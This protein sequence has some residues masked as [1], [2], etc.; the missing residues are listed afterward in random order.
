MKILQK[1][2]ID[3]VNGG[4]SLRRIAADSGVE[5]TSI[6]NYFHKNMKDIKSQNLKMLSDYFK[7]PFYSL[8]EDADSSA[9]R[10]KDNHNTY[11]ATPNEEQTLNQI[12]EALPHLS[13]EGLEK[14]LLSAL[15]RTTAKKAEKPDTE[16]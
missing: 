13:V 11:V 12:L 5:Y 15:Q 8:L 1:L 3:E 10:I 16:S 6:Y 9:F 2:I 4:K 7:V 14:V